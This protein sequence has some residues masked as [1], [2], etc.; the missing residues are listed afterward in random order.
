MAKLTA[1]A[2]NKVL[3]QLVITGRTTQ[4]ELNTFSEAELYAIAHATD[5]YLQTGESLA[6][7]EIRQSD[8]IT[9]LPH[10]IEYIESPHYLG[11][12]LGYLED[13]DGV[14]SNKRQLYDFWTNKFL[15]VVEGN[16]TEVLI[17]GGIGIGKTTFM[18]LIQ[19]W[20]TMKVC[21]LANPQRHYRLMPS[22]KIVFAFFSVGLSLATDVSYSQFQGMLDNSPFFNKLL[23]RN[24]K[25]KEGFQMQPP[26]SKRVMFK[27]GS[28]I[29][30]SLGFAVFGSEIDEANFGHETVTE[31]DQ[32]KKSQVYDN[33]T[34]LKRRRESR[35]LNADGHFLVGSSKRG[36]TS[37]LEKHIDDSRGKPGVLVID[38]PQ[39]EVK[40]G[41]VSYCGT[42][43][44]VLLGDVTRTPRILADNE[45]I[46][47]GLESKVETIPVEYKQAYE[48]NIYDALR[49]ISGKAADS[50]SALITNRQIILD[51]L[52]TRLAPFTFVD[53]KHKPPNTIYISFNGDDQ[54]QDHLIKE[55]L[56]YKDGKLPYPSAP[57]YI[58]IDT[59]YSSDALGL[60]MVCRAGSKITKKDNVLHFQPKYHVDFYIRVKGINKDKYPL[61]KTIIFLQ[62]LIDTLGIYVA[63]CACDGFQS[64][65]LQHE[66]MAKYIGMTVTQ[67]STDKTDEIP[68]HIRSMFNAQVIEGL[69]QDTNFFVE[70]FDLLHLTSGKRGSATDK[71]RMI[72]NHPAVASDGFVG[73]KDVV[74]GCFLALAACYADDKSE[75]IEESKQRLATLDT[76]DLDKLNKQIDT[77][78]AD[79]DASLTDLY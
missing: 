61:F 51:K 4:A 1:Y 45:V 38:A 56:F 36:E 54:I 29:S 41:F 72:V 5:E 14:V 35:F 65:Q 43:F 79:V 66:L 17:T 63:G 8:Y 57:R 18:N 48:D 31:K 28:T 19:S 15:E 3:T 32:A 11:K 12:E 77:I 59:G 75:S 76:L 9:R 37:F 58:G 24:K 42:N 30:H 71:Q 22:T 23:V 34:S 47:P 39:Y 74:D 60:A 53:Q 50:Q 27:V 33:Y 44:R 40:R 7:Q 6:I 26:P 13:D 70:L 78:L 10:P 67:M 46:E 16:Y 2:V 62:Y 55:H 49:D 25:L 68:V 21:A 69:Y 52:T 20:N 64:V 73:R